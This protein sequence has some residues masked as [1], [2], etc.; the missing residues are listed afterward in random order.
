VPIGGERKFLEQLPLTALPDPHVELLRRLYLF[1]IT[2][3]G[4]FAQLLRLA[5]AG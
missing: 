5:V 4:G 1:G 2:T 3:L